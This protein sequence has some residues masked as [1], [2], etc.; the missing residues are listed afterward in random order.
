ES[1][2]RSYLDSLPPVS[3]RLRFDAS[4]YI[5]IRRLYYDIP[6]SHWAFIKSE[7][8]QRNLQN[9]QGSARLSHPLIFRRGQFA[10]SDTYLEPEILVLR[11]LRDRFLRRDHR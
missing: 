9:D 1:H 10:T 11:V 3:F 4:I 5:W 8:Q 6:W 2:E 7:A